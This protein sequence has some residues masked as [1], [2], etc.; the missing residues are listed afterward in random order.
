M[1]KQKNIPWLGAFVEALYNSLPILSIINFL[2]I[3]TVLYATTKPYLLEYAPWLTIWM[4]I[5]FLVVLTFL[6]MF[7]T[8]KFVLPSI[9]TFRGKQMFGYESQVK[10]QL[11]KILRKLEEI[12]N[13]SRHHS[14]N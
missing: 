13:G 8:Y 2:S 1:I 6:V 12:E 5:S 4:F 9:W 10:D 3:L 14:A 7:L 11:D